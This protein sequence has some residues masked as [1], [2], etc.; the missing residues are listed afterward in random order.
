[1]TTH[2]PTPWHAE[3]NGDPDPRGHRIYGPNNEAICSMCHWRSDDPLEELSANLAHIVTCVNTHAELLEALKEF[4]EAL[5][6]K[7]FKEVVWSK[8]SQKLYNAYE[9]AGQAIAK[10]E[11]K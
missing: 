2:T 6:R 11:G 8:E 9:K 3:D 10:A 1:M 5:G 4:R 7:H